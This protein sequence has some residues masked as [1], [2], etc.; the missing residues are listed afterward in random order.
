MRKV[1]F[2]TYY[3]PPSGGPGVQRVLYFAKYLPQYGYEPIILTVKKG[4]YPAIDHSMLNLIP[5]NLKVYKTKTIEPFTWYK[6]ITGKSSD[7]KIDTYILSKKHASF[8]ERVLQWIRLNLFIPDARIGWIFFA[9]KKALEIVSNHDIALIYSCS[10]PHSVQL[11]ANTVS[12]KTGVKW[13]ADFRDPWSD[14]VYHQENKRLRIIDVIDAKLEKRIF[15]NANIILTTCHGLRSHLIKKQ[16]LPENKI[17]V[18]TN[19]Y[20]PQQTISP[21]NNKDDI[22]IVTYAGNLSVTRTP[23]SLLKAISVLNNRN[24]TILIRFRIAGTV[25]DEFQK[26]VTSYGLMDDIELLGYLPHEKILPIYQSSDLL[27]LV[28]D[29]VPSSDLFIAGKLFDYMGAKRPILVFGDQ[30]GEVNQIIT[31][32][33]SGKFIHYDDVSG[34]I[35]FLEDQIDS[36][37][38]KKDTGF[39]FHNIK[40][41]SRKVLTGKLASIFN[42][43]IDS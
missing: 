4:E 29:R 34:T 20:E 8:R 23:E 36:K 19:G 7:H 24:N 28:I 35:T 39:S 25:S 6:K 14:I 17:K 30:P 11:I 5:A 38:N 16:D 41:Y 37:I 21:V 12:S 42:T 18:I 22:Y 43:L 33:N 10:P 31:E 3:W 9:R 27:L 1:L 13:V 32:T 26:L 2:I 15:K 40:Q